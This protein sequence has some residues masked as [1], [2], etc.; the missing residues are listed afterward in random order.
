[1]ARRTLIHLDERI[2]AWAVQ[3]GSRK[4]IEG[5]STARIASQLRISE[6][7]IFI[8]FKNKGNLLR[9]AYLFSLRALYGSIAPIPNENPRKNLL[10]GLL[11]LAQNAE[12]NPAEAAYAQ[13]FGA[14]ADLSAPLFDQEARPLLDLLSPGA[15]SLSAP[16][17]LALQD[18]LGAFAY[19]ASQGKILRDEEHLTPM[20]NALIALAS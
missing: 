7:T 16:C 10:N 2:L 4:G 6:P 9:E 19:R 17:S 1:M 11:C 20:L 15:P 12:K 3:E 13:A 18:A 8:H 5:I 14:K